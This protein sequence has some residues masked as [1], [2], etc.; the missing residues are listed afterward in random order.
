[1]LFIYCIYFKSNIHCIYFKSNIDI[2]IVYIV[3]V[4]DAKVKGRIMDSR[5]KHTAC[6]LYCIFCKYSKF[7]IFLYCIYTTHTLYMSGLLRVVCRRIM[8]SRQRLT[9]SYVHLLC[10]FHI[11]YYRH[12]NAWDAEVCG[13]IMDCRQ[14][15]IACYSY[16][17]YIII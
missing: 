6:Y 5:R 17:V 7:I 9:A 13:R 10:I 3:Y 1:M 15:H 12:H 4:W 8:D 14:R 16:I 11:L 2:Y